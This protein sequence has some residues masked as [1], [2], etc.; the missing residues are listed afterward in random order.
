MNDKRNLQASDFCRCELFQRKF[1]T[2]NLNLIGARS[3]KVSN[4]KQFIEVEE[5][6]NLKKFLKDMNFIISTDL[7]EIENS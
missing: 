4:L 2:S 1:K 7:D 5:S 3:I 6:L